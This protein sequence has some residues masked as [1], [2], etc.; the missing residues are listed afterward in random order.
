MLSWIM[1]LWLNTH[2]KSEWPV[3]PVSQPDDAIHVTNIEEHPS[4][5]DIEKMCSRGFFNPHKY[6][7]V[8]S[9]RQNETDTAEV[10]EYA[11]TSFQLPPPLCYPAFHQSTPRNFSD[12]VLN[13]ADQH[14]TNQTD[15]AAEM[16]VEEP[17][18]WII[19]NDEDTTDCLSSHVP[20]SHS[21]AGEDQRLQ[22]HKDCVAGAYSFNGDF[23]DETNLN[24]QPSHEATGGARGRSTCVE[25]A[26][27]DSER[28]QKLYEN[29]C[30]RDLA[31]TRKYYMPMRNNAKKP[32]TPGY[33]NVLT[34]ETGAQLSQTGCSNKD[35]LVNPYMCVDLL[36]QVL[37]QR[38]EDIVTTQSLSCNEHGV[39]HQPSFEL[40][41]DMAIQLILMDAESLYRRELQ[42]RKYE[43]TIQES[44]YENQGSPLE[45]V[46]FQEHLNLYANVL[47]NLS[48]GS[49]INTAMK[50]IGSRSV[51]CDKET[52]L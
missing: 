44:L 52:T 1:Q 41:E 9:V 14:E 28:E 5:E 21:V 48:L 43:E 35:T 46:C 6:L 23:S 42:R 8:D 47:T 4:G 49:S 29:A 10:Y 26:K 3:L 38:S 15:S 51:G 22:N 45:Q 7:Y 40:Y 17:T 18:Y 34:E 25:R 12:G 11:Y 2:E 36:G 30:Y 24:E 16:V 20:K 37:R 33:I 32:K 50:S 39:E 13:V 31:L 19:K 27:Y